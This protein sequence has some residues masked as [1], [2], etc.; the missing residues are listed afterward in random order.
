M[1]SIRRR[2]LAGAPAFVRRFSSEVQATEP[3]EQT[4]C[5]YR[6]LSKL[7]HDKGTV[8]ST[9]NEYIIEGKSV[10]RFELDRCINELRKYRRFDHALE[11]MEWMEFRKFNFGQRDYAVRLDLIAKVKGIAEAENYFSGLSP[12]MRVHCTYGALLNRYCEEKMTDKALGLFCK[13]FKEN[14]MIRPLPFNHLMSLYMRSGQP[15]KVVSLFQEM[16]KMNIRPDTNSYN[17]LMNSYSHLNDIEGVE[18]VFE[19]MR[20]E[21]GKLCNWT[22]YS[23]LANI[24]ARGGYQEK[25]KLALINV[26][27]MGAHDR[28][29]YHFLISLYAGISDL[30]NVHRVWEKLKSTMKVVTNM[31]YL[32][33]LQALGNLNDIEGMTKCFEE[34][35][36]V[37]CSYDTRL[38]NPVVCAYLKHDM[39]EEAESVL[40]RASKKTDTPFFKAL[41][42]FMVFHLEKG[43]IKQA[44]EIVEKATSRYGN[45]EWRPKPDTISRFLDYFKQEN[46][47]SSAEEFYE[48]MKRIN[49]VDRRLYESLLETYVGAGRSMVDIR[50]RIERDGI[51]TSGV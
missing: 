31:S 41:E 50:A 46:D 23:Y 49:C 44:F 21:N 33:M 19:E 16:K 12:S 2:L 6:R 10:G 35:E 26:E 5:L 22:S 34:W 27:E 8:A 40:E 9:I 37:C 47:V 51:E 15:E 7:W 3:L 38:V 13:M 45:T 42:M 14:M 1:A 11:I 24:Y 48:L 43:Q 39:V 32:I 29:A 30:D 28:V 25:A 36:S 4:D 18:R 17:L 20:L